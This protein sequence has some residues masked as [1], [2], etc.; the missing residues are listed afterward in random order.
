MGEEQSLNSKPMTINDIL[1][2]TH[3]KA[4][5]GK[6]RFQLNSVIWI[7]SIWIG[8]RSLDDIR[9]VLKIGTDACKVPISFSAPQIPALISLESSV[10]EAAQEVVKF[11]DSSK[12]NNYLNIWARYLDHK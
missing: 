12:E 11:S 7:C 1:K 3:E 6:K 9:C 8:S 10:F 2:N 5:T 4:L